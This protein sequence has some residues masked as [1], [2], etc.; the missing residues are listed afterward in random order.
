MKNERSNK[1]KRLASITLLFGMTSSS[2]FA[3]LIE[4]QIDE[5]LIS[6]QCSHQ[7][8]SARNEEFQIFLSAKTQ[9]AIKRCVAERVKEARYDLRE[10][11][12]FE[13]TVNDPEFR[14]NLANI[15]QTIDTNMNESQRTIDMELNAATF[16]EIRKNEI[17]N[18]FGVKPLAGFKNLSGTDE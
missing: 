2:T 4:P 5:D 1:I 12:Y 8:K 9:G 6:K 7:V 13:S 11:N 16:N 14:E 18:A 15:E 10:N 3:D 17:N